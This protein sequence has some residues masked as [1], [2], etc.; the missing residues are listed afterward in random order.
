MASKLTILL[1]QSLARIYRFNLRG[2]TLHL[3]GSST[4]RSLR[5]ARYPQL[6]RV[7]GHLLRSRLG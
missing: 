4:A 1:K 5:V 3:L 6:L 7:P 2:T